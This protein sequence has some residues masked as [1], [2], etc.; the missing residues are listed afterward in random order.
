MTQIIESLKQVFSPARAGDW[1]AANLPKVIV[2][3][4]IFLAFWVL[5]RALYASLSFVFRRTELDQTVAEFIHTLV[6]YAVLAIGLIM[7]LGHVGVDTTS[8]LASLGVAGL[9]I[10]FAARDALSNVISGVFIFWDRP[11]V[12][13]DLVEI[14]GAYG[15]VDSITMRSTRVVTPDGRMLAIPNSVVI[16][17]SVASYTNFPRLRLDVEVTVAVTENLARVREVL[18]DMVRSDPGFSDEP[19]PEVVVKALN[20]YNVLLEVRVWIDDERKHVAER[21]RLRE[22]IFVTL[23]EAG[24]EMPYETLQLAPFEMRA[25]TVAP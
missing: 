18:L 12:I 13:G 8:V 11:F 5:W 25:A 3:F 10:G 4:V 20:D 14:G 1:I 23:N 15:R 24:V 7:A 22:A 6:R 17:S 2:A 21:F 9:T 16:N 19:A